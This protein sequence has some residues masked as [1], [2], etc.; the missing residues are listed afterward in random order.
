[1]KRSPTITIISPSL[2]KFDYTSFV[3]SLHIIELLLNGGEG[4]LKES[5]LVKPINIVNLKVEFN[6]L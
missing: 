4:E 3:D 2:K 6:R 1:M 5:G